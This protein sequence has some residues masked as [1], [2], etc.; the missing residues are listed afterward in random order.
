MESS[1]EKRE[2]PE[3]NKWRI[4]ATARARALAA[5]YRK[6][7]A[8][9]R[10]EEILKALSAGQ[11]ESLRLFIERKMGGPPEA[12]ARSLARGGNSKEMKAAMRTAA[13]WGRVDL[14][15][16][17]VALGGDPSEKSPEGRSLLMEA[18]K[19]ERAVA[20]QELAAWGLSVS[21]GDDSGGSPLRNAAITGAGV[22]LEEAV[23]R[24]GERGMAYVKVEELSRFEVL[25]ALL[26]LG[27]KI[28]EVSPVT[29]MTA[30]AEICG[31]GDECEAAVRALLERGA[32]PNA[33]GPDGELAWS[34]AAGCG[35]ESGQVCALL[36]SHGARPTP[37]PPGKTISASALAA[38]EAW[39]LGRGAEPRVSLKAPRL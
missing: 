25:D 8:Q 37:L 22:A 29:G 1:D 31:G 27:A 30:L 14:L 32:D 16:G 7:G 33:K 17:L 36:L 18:S 10:V 39:E 35:W 24:S 20:V 9:K 26:V 13:G 34:R 2:A 38:L 5:G 3:E 11:S 21:E 12:K 4:I 15:M 6:A 23:F 19:S 28:D